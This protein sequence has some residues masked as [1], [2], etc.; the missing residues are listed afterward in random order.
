MKPLLF[1]T[2]LLTF[3]A[4][5]AQDKNIQKGKEKMV[6]GTFDE[7]IA[8]FSKSIKKSNSIEAYNLRAESYLHVNN[9]IAA[10]DDY[11]ISLEIKKEQIDTWIARGKVYLK[12]GNYSKA[13]EDFTTALQIDAKNTEALLE[14]GET[15]SKLHAMEK[16]CADWAKSASLGEKRAQALLK[17][18]CEDPEEYSTEYM[19]NK[20]RK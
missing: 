11:S 3:F 8:Y 17:L 2:C 10:I 19:Q 7:A 12:N 5:H 9:K 18:R 15:Y 13:E 1:L 14:R 16:A 20:I 4:S 6:E